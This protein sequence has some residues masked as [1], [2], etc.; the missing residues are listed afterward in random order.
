VAGIAG[1]WRVHG[2]VAERVQT[3]TARLHVTLRRAMTANDNVRRAVAKAREDVAGIGE[4]SSGLDGGGE[5]ASRTRRTLGS[6][7]QQRV[8]PDLEDLHG[9]L[10]T[11][12]DGAVAV[13][14]LLQSAQDAA[15]GRI[16]DTAGDQVDQWADEAQRLSAALRRLER[17]VGDGD[18]EPTRSEV[19]GATGEVDA[20]LQ[21]C[22]ATV[23]SWQ[24]GLEAASDALAQT[25]ANARGYLKAAAVGVTLLCV[26]VALGQ[27]SLF[28]LALGWCK[29]PWT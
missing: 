6:L 14:S 18:R 1:A 27:G 5:E 3:I 15:A 2:V 9:R 22:V 19:A 21:R 26:W 7:V 29:R 28:A 12:A 20:V 8:G 11:L 23:E 25:E 10:A 24:A 16:G 13:S 4:A 17:V